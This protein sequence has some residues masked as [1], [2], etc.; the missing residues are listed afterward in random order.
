MWKDPKIFFFALVDSGADASCLPEHVARSMGV[1]FS[2]RKRRRAMGAGGP[3]TEYRAEEDV[4]LMTSAGPVVLERPA[5][6][7]H[8]TEVILGRQDFFAAYR[9]TF[10]SSAQTLIIQRLPRARRR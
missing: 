10:D 1:R 7:P 4:E 8:L 3:F 6:N 5:I 2:K 9:V